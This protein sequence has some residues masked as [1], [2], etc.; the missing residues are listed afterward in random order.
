MYTGIVQELG[1]ITSLVEN[2]GHVSATIFASPAFL[3]G[4]KIGGSISVNGVCLS[5]TKIDEQTFSADITRTTLVITNLAHCV[6]GDSVN[7]ERS[8]LAGAE[9]GGHIISGHIDGTA[10]V[11]EI[12]ETG[13]SKVFLLT[14]PERILK[15]IFDR[16]FVA[17][18]GAS[19]TVAVVDLKNNNV[20]VNLIPE[21]L[22]Q[23]T[24]SLAKPGDTL[25]IEVEST[26]KVLVNTLERILAPVVDKLQFQG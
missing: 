9:V 4:L 17:I 18:N 11:T 8:A 20:R 3:H 24:F 15:F 1:R 10:T 23:T 13:E 12:L 6:V 5:A 19:L 21:T 26:A 14:V 25:N 16:G 7:L 22:R 2:E